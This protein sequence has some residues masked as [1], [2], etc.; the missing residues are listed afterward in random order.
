MVFS[1]VLWHVTYPRTYSAV[2]CFSI[3]HQKSL[4]KV[5]VMLVIPGCPASGWSWY[6]RRISCRNFSSSGTIGCPWWNH[7]SSTL[8]RGKFCHSS[9]IH[10]SC[11]SC[12][13]NTLC[14]KLRSSMAFVKSSRPRMITFLLSKVP[15]SRSSRH[16][17]A[18]VQFKVPGL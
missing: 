4:A 3:G 16:E 6:C 12:V 2:K 18:S 17:N 11:L 7:H 1:F 10:F 13:V 15:A 8:F 9:S 14:S 5:M